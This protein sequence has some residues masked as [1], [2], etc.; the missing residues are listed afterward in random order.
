MQIVWFKRDLRLED[1][2]PLYKA[3][4]NKERILLLYVFEP[5]LKTEGHYSERH[6]DFIKQSLAEMQ[7]LLLPFHTQILVIES[8][9]RDKWSSGYKGFPGLPEGFYGVVTYKVD[10]TANPLY[11]VME[12]DGPDWKD[13]SPAYAYYIR[14]LDV[15]HGSV[16][17]A[18]QS[19]PI[20]MNFFLYEGESLTTNGI[21]ITLVKS[22]DHDEVRIEKA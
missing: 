7:N 10:T 17:G 1:H 19:G 3:M 9:R 13:S 6:F 21:K 2:A 5:S 4:Q 20:D 12:P 14:N 8:R 16:K 22:G 11:G 18:P 15:D